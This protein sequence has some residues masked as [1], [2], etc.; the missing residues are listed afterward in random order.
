MSN[1]FLARIAAWIMSTS[2]PGPQLLQQ[3]KQREVTV[4][5]PK[6]FSNIDRSHLTK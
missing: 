1:A 4:L 3:S 6:I 2:L 5:I